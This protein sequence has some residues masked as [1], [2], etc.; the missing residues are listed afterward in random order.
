M[1]KTNES[2]KSFEIY[3]HGIDCESVEMCIDTS[4]YFLSNRLFRAALGNVYKYLTLYL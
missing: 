4:D 3:V 2:C 1:I